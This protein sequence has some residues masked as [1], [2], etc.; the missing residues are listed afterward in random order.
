[1]AETMLRAFWFKQLTHMM[2]K[3][4][5]VQSQNLHGREKI[6]GAARQ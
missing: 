3:Q 6:P 2:V 1:M 4:S 5:A